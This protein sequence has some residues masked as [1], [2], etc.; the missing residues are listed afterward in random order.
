MKLI[1]FDLDQTIMDIFKFHNKTTEITFKKVF[2]VKAKMDEVDYVGKTLKRVLTE[3]AV[4]KG[5]KK[6]ERQKKIPKAIKLYEKTL[7][8][9]LPENTNSYLLPGASSLIKKLSKDKNK[10]LIVL[11]GDSKKIAKTA[12]KRACLLKNFQFL[13]TGEHTKSRT[14]MMKKAL[15]KAHRQT[16]QKKFEKVIIIGDS[17]HDIEAGKAVGALTIAVLTGNDSKYKLKKEGANYIF[18]N[19]KDKK[20]LKIIEK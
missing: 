15:K 11:T 18:K 10:F 2:G 4:L 13:I 19:L 9:I 3:L 6:N 5:I 14:K 17:T 8:S 16:K 20:I 1:V 12:L 7:I